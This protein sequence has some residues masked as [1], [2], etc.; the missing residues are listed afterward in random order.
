M[1][2]KETF[3]V[4]RVFSE[5]PWLS[6][7]AVMK[8]VDDIKI[9]RLDIETMNSLLD[10]NGEEDVFLISNNGTTV[11]QVGLKHRRWFGLM[12]CRHPI[13]TNENIADAIM[14]IGE[15]ASEKVSFILRIR[16]DDTGY[17]TL[18]VYKMPSAFPTMKSWIG[19]LR[20][21]SANSVEQQIAQIDSEALTA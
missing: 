5:F 18:T 3:K 11:T 10:W 17:A 21:R 9:S 1:Y 6:K 19:E 4:A 13:I 15:M 7:Y 14:R 12:L 2:K 8:M 16:H 20:R